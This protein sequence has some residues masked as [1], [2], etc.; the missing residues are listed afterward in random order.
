MICENGFLPTISAAVLLSD[1][2]LILSPDIHSREYQSHQDSK[3]ANQSKHSNTFLL[4]L[5]KTYKQS[6]A[7]YIYQVLDNIVLTH[8]F[9]ILI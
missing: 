2:I 4:G 9:K 1:T 6:S 7:N 8:L 3:A 5:H